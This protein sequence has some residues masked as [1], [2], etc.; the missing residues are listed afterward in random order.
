MSIWVI[1]QPKVLQEENEE[2]GVW[3]TFTELEKVNFPYFSGTSLSSIPEF[4]L[5]L[6]LTA[7]VIKLARSNT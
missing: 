7:L 2:Y 6:L 5:L 4:F 1:P 3:H